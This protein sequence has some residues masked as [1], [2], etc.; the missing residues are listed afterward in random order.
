VDISDIRSMF[1]VL[2]GVQTT[3]VQITRIA[4]V[5]EPGTA[6]LLGAGL[7]GLAVRRHGRR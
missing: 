6:L 7:V 4:A 1:F 3:P 5:P 2:D